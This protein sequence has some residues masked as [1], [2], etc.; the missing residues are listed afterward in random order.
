MYKFCDAFHRVVPDA[1]TFT[2]AIDEYALLIT[3]NDKEIAR[4][5]DASAPSSSDTRLVKNG[6]LL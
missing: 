5:T 4:L 6:M 2:M 1:K 3:P